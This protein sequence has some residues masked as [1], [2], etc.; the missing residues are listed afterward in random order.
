MLYRFRACN[1]FLFEELDKKYIYFSD[2]NDFNDYGENQINLVFQGDLI[3]WKGFLKHY[4][5]SLLLTLSFNNFAN[6]SKIFL[7]I[8]NYDSDYCTYPL[9]I[10]KILKKISFDF[11]EDEFVKYFLSVIVN[12]KISQRKLFLIISYLHIRALMIINDSQNKDEIN[13]LAPFEV[14][15][16]NL[17][18]IINLNNIEELNEMI[19]QQEAIE[20]LPYLKNLKKR[21]PLIIVDFPKEY[22]QQSKKI[23]YPDKYIACFSEVFSNILMWG[24]YSDSFSGVC[25]EFNTVQDNNKKYIE[26]YDRIGVNNNGTFFDWEKFYFKQVIY[27]NSE[28]TFPE[29]NFFENIG[30]I[31]RCYKSLFLI[32]NHESSKYLENSEEWRLKYW[33]LFENLS[34]H[35]LLDWKHEKEWRLIK[36][37]T[38]FSFDDIENRKLKYKF[39]SLNGIIFGNKVTKKNKDRIIKIIAKNCIEEGRKEFD[40]FNLI[41]LNGKLQ[42]QKCIYSI[43][44][45]KKILKKRNL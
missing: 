21:K 1:K 35:K 29:V 41:Y 20:I 28:E 8:E 6:D 34:I 14:F 37:N 26:L 10:R 5:S 18:R 11:L 38:F 25:L 16:E 4:I 42:K 44:R 23:L 39:S 30:M 13:K 12:K 27:S 7:N 3:A 36:D 31:P 15:K 32:E 19:F 43:L 2:V 33:K 24:Y 45:L 40:F 17:D 22:L 9:E